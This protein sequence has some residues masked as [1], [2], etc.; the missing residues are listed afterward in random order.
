MAGLHGGDVRVPAARGARGGERTDRAH[1]VH[2]PSLQRRRR[3]LPQRLVRA[4]ALRGPRADCDAHL[5]EPAERVAGARAVRGE[6]RGS[7]YRHQLFTVQVFEVQVR[8]RERRGRRGRVRGEGRR[9]PRGWRARRARA[10]HQQHGDRVRDPPLRARRVAR[11]VSEREPGCDRVG[12]DPGRLGVRDEVR[13][14][15]LHR[16]RRD[17]E[18]RARVRDA[19]RHLVRGGRRAPGRAPTARSTSTA[20]SRR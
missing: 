12:R 13:A 18:R 20:P 9:E 4:L 2:D 1:D 15:R 14:E 11:A 8:G 5:H 10:L 3:E 7:R 19:A 6:H 16:R 17:R